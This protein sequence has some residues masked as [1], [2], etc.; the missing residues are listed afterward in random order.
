[1]DLLDSIR[2]GITGPRS[3]IL[4]GE[5][6]I[7]RLADGKVETRVFHYK[8]AEAE[9]H[10]YEEARQALRDWHKNRIDV[11]ESRNISPEEVARAKDTLRK[12]Q[13]IGVQGIE[14]QEKVNG[15]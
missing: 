2:S 10:A 9:R 12:A 5:V 7:S 4:E 11:Q 8:S 1:M 14:S 13:L 6:T 15:G 3:P